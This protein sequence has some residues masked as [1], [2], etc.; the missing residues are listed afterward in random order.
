MLFP[1]RLTLRPLSL[2][3]LLL[4][5]V[6]HTTQADDKLEAEKEEM[7]EAMALEVEEVVL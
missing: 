4:L 3:F 2:I 5:L 1:C 6:P 7:M